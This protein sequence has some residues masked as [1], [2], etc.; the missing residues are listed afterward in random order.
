LAIL[1]GSIY[2]IPLLGYLGYAGIPMPKS[3]DSYG[4]AIADKIMPVYS[5]GLILSTVLLVVIS[6][7]IVSYFPSSKISKMKPTD[8]LKGKMQ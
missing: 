4:L 3:M 6:A 5:M 2:G 1:L 7:T 8:A